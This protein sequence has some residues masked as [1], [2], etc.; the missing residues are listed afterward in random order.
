MSLTDEQQAGVVCAVPA[1]PPRCSDCDGEA[2][3]AHVC[4]PA[5]ATP[6]ASKTRH[7]FE[8]G[9]VVE[10]LKG[11]RAGQTHPVLDVYLAYEKG[12]RAGVSIRDEDTEL[13]YALDE[14][15]SVVEASPVAR[16]EAETRRCI[17]GNNGT[18]CKEC[19][20]YFREKAKAATADRARAF[21]R[22]I[23]AGNIAHDDRVTA[24][25]DVLDA[26]PGAPPSLR[27]ASSDEERAHLYLYPHDVPEMGSTDSRVWALVSLI[28][29]V[30]RET[31]EACAKVCDD[32]RDRTMLGHSTARECAAAIRKTASP[33]VM[34]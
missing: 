11:K 14:V 12:E 26:S 6:N 10:I 5:C 17:H 28:R 18:D 15:S 22:A 27:I 2:G 8:R 33:V 30:R 4:P 1:G 13:F 16:S 3:E 25:V 23:D 24:L 21:F 32:V 34:P 31:I 20:R 19:A 7:P 29:D 9:Q